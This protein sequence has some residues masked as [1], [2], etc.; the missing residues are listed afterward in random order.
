MKTVNLR[1]YGATNLGDD[2]FI[3]IILDRYK[4]IIVIN[5]CIII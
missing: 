4:N 3:K 1:Y 2:I 5:K